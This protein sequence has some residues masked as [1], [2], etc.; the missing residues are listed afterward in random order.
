MKPCPLCGG[1][2]RVLLRSPDRNQAVAPGS[3]T[4]ARC[5]ACETVWLT[6]P[7]DDLGAWYPDDYFELL[8]LEGLRER[9]QADAYRL[10][11]VAPFAGA[12]DGSGRL[13][14]LGP[15]YG[16]FALLAKDAGFDVTGIEQDPRAAAY[17]EE[18]VG[19]RVVR[20]AEPEAVLPELPPSRVVAAWHVLEHVRRP[21]DVL[22]AIAG[23]LEPG[24]VTVIAM[25]NPDA[26]GF[27]VLGSRWPHLDAPRHLFLIRAQELIRRGRALGLEPVA[28]RHADPG[29]RG[30]NH[31][32]W[33]Y[34]LRPPGASA[35]RDRA[36][37]RAAWLIATALSPVETRGFRGATYTA[38][39]RKP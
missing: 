20:S 16:S 19:A 7:P 26:F 30:W 23:N 24:G 15:G 6:D 12:G 25:P 36:A 34:A 22:E 11:L 9:A 31:F 33:H 4:Y 1:A 8:P 18:V 35:A 32:A 21:W 29:G 28:L 38:I 14:E 39:L 13:T 17:L 27:R 5:S 2:S 3:F 37:A 10:E